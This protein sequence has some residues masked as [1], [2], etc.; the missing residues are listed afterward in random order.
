MK[1]DAPLFGTS[2]HLGG[3]LI[4]DLANCLGARASDLSGFSVQVLTDPFGTATDPQAELN[5]ILGL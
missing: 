3:I 4:D 1:G 2:F 5:E